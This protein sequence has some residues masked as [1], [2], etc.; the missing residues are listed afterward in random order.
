LELCYPVTVATA[1][2]GGSVAVEPATVSA[3]QDSGRRRQT[4]KTVAV[5]VNRTGQTVASCPRDD[6]S[7]QT[8]C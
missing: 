2:G 6:N 7:Q 5:D 8:A 1:A 4:F 3:S